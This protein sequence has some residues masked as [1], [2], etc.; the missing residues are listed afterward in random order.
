MVKQYF[1]DIYK[2]K[3]IIIKSY[4]N[5]SYDLIDCIIL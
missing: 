1:N 5:V 4:K 2:S 3:T